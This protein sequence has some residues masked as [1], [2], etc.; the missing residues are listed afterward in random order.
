MERF[1]IKNKK[2]GYFLEDKSDDKLIELGDIVLNKENKRKTS[3]C[4]QREE[5]YNYRGIQNAVCGKIRYEE[6]GIMVGEYFNPTRIFVIQM[7]EL[8]KDELKIKEELQKKQLEEWTGLIYGETIFDSEK[9]DW[10]TKQC[11]FDDRI[12]RKK[13][14]VFLIEDDRGEKFGYYLHTNIPNCYEKWIS[15][16]EE[17]FEFNL[18]SNGRLKRMMKFPIEDIH[19]GG[20]YLYEKTEEKLI[21]LGDILLKKQN[22]SNTSYCYKQKAKSNFNYQ[23]IDNAICGKTNIEEKG[24]WKGEFF[25][26][27][28]IR[29]IQMKKSEEEKQIRKQKKNQQKKQ[30]EEWT[31]LK[32]NEI[33]FDS[34][35]NNWS[36]RKSVF[37]KYI[38][39]RKQLVFLI[40]DNNGEIFG[41]YLNT[42]VKKEYNRQ[43]FTQTDV[44][45]FEFNLES[46]GRLKAPMKFPIK[47]TSYGYFLPNSLN[48]RLIEIGDIVLYKEHKKDSSFCVQEDKRYDYQG[49]ENPLCGKSVYQEEGI[50]FGECINPSRIRVI[51][52]DSTDDRKK[53][54]KQQIHQLEEWCGMKYGFVLFDSDSDNWTTIKN[55]F[56]KKI[57]GRK[58]LLFIIEDDRN[59]KFGYYI[60]TTID[61]YNQWIETDQK[62]FSFNI[63]S[64]GRIESMVK[65]PI[66]DLSYGCFVYYQTNETLIEIGDI[67][68]KKQEKK[69]LSYCNQ[70]EERYDY[71]GFE[72]AICG[73]TLTKENKESD[74]N[75][76]FYPLRFSVIQMLEEK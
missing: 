23:G 15:T 28:Q 49:L 10:S 24:K 27:I 67:V 2:S 29:V 74:D 70:N 65:F 64:N 18:E 20:S 40:N 56:D 46:N 54:L 61:K 48:E 50:W 60:N 35:I 41:Y 17:S 6:N 22:K 13:H 11:E 42:E 21:Y 37:D 51:Q 31:G 45:S 53:I 62:S 8:T 75:H 1:S 7:R 72:N 26:P 36:I 69:H 34:Y 4:F 68:L 32:C 39:G 47:D 63:E 52:M 3:Y 19:Y 43:T 9:D 55:D 57:K 58:Q 76:N 66:K 73:R 14:L 59:E 38:Q 25:S 33:V 44:F 30:L 71:K 5:K 16:D 12:I